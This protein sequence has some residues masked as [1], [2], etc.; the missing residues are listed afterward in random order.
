MT[1]LTGA[2]HVSWERSDKYCESFSETLNTKYVIPVFPRDHRSKLRIKG[3]LDRTNL[4]NKNKL[5]KFE[6]SFK[7]T[8]LINEVLPFRADQS[9]VLHLLEAQ[10]V[11][12]LPQEF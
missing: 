12:N 8:A 2:G 3:C 9:T 7:T 10:V 11:E 4:Y 5:T 1:W 6:K